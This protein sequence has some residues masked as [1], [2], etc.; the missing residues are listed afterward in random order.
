MGSKLR[1]SIVR[2]NE[3]IYLL[4]IKPEMSV[5]RKPAIVSFFFAERQTKTERQTE[6]AQTSQLK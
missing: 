6:T 2:Q 1:P 5:H 3:N 4:E